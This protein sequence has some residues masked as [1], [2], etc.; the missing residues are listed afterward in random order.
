MLKFTGIT[1]LTAPINCVRPLF[2]KGNAFIVYRFAHKSF[3]VGKSV[4]NGMDQV[5]TFPLVEGASIVDAVGFA[6]R[7]ADEYATINTKSCDRAEALAIAPNNGDVYE[8]KAVWYGLKYRPPRINSDII[9][10][11]LP[12]RSTIEVPRV[13]PFNKETAPSAALTTGAMGEPLP[14][15]LVWKCTARSG[16]ARTNRFC[17]PNAR[18]LRKRRERHLV[19]TIR[20]TYQTKNHYEPTCENS[21]DLCAYAYN[22]KRVKSDRIHTL[23]DNYPTPSAHH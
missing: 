2:P 22:P 7:G 23:L 17:R 4:T 18:R 14:T 5:S 21:N 19:Q 9:L 10:M 3:I 13:I 15:L 20:N 1:G 12:V 11:R 16:R 8:K 6:A